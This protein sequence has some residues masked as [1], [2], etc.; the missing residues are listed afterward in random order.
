M[1]LN[2]IFELL[3]EEEQDELIRAGLACCGSYDSE[4][5]CC[6]FTHKPKKVLK[7]GNDDPDENNS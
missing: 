4:S 1:M 6:P 5:G 3:T 2:P 7:T